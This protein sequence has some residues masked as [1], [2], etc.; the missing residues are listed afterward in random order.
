[1]ASTSAPPVP[2]GYDISRPS[3]ARIRPSR[4]QARGHRKSRLPT[5]HDAL[6]GETGHHAVNRHRLRAAHRKQHAQ[7][8]AA[9]GP[10]G[11]SRVRRRRRHRGPAGARD[12]RGAAPAG[13]R[14]RHPRVGAGAGDDSEAPEMARLID[15][16]R[17]GW[18]RDDGAGALLL[19]GA[20]EIEPIFQ[21]LQVVEPGIVKVDKWKM[22]EAEGE[23]QPELTG[24][25]Y[26]GIG[27]VA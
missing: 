5:V 6:D 8:R 3:I 7:R 23:C 26:G 10:R 17:P 15:L 12:H 13:E 4:N 22:N 21:G 2:E 19:A 14:G 1:M 16:G 25:W 27:K 18:Y 20:A 24:M 11:Q 9:P